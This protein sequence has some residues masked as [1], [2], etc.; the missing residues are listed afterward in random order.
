MSYQKKNSQRINSS[1]SSVSEAVALRKGFSFPAVAALQ[2]HSQGP[3]EELLQGK[4]E[5]VQKVEEE[6][7]L[8]GKF[9]P[10]QKAED[11]ELLQGKFEPVQK[12][13]DEELL[14]GKF[15]P[16]Q[17]VEEEEPLQGKFEP[18]QKAED[19]ELLQGKFEPVQK[20]EDEELLQGKFEPVQKVEEEEPL[21]GKFEPVQKVEDEELLQGKFEPVQKVEEEE[22]L[23]GKFETVQKVEEEE[24]LQGK[25]ETVQ[26]VEEEEPLQGKFESVQNQSVQLSN[27]D[28]IGKPINPVQRAE[29]APKENNTGLPDR[30]KSGIE[31]L[32]G[33]SLDD[34]KVHYNSAKPA[35]LQAHAYA[36]GTNIHVAP[37]QERHIAHE[38]WHVV[39]QKQGRVKPTLQMKSG[40][41][42]NDEE[43]LE[44]EADLMGAKAQVMDNQMLIN[45]PAQLKYRNTS[46]NTKEIP[47][48]KVIQKNEL[49]RGRASRSLDT[50]S[51]DDKYQ[52]MNA[53]VISMISNAGAV[54]SKIN[55]KSLESGSDN[56]ATAT[57]VG[58]LTASLTS[59]SGSATNAIKGEGKPDISGAAGDITLGIGSTIGVLVKSVV[60][61]KKG[62][63]S[64]K[65]KESTLVGGGETAIA[66]LSALKAGCEAAMSIQ[67]YVTGSVPPAIVSLIPGLGI[68][69][70]ACEVIKNAYT[71][72]NAYS[73]ESEMTSVS[74]EFRAELVKLLGGSPETSAPS[75]FANEKRGKYGNRITYLRLKPGL[76]ETLASIND[77]D[78]TS[79]QK[80]TRANNFKRIHNIPSSVDLN[81]LLPA[82]KY[83]ELG[84]KMQEINQK[85]KVQGA[86]NIFT[87]LLTMAG[88][89]AKFFPA[90][91]GITAGVLIGAAA[92]SGAV[93]SAGKFIQGLARDKGILSADTNRSSKNKHKE[94]VNH[95][96]T[97]YELFNS[98]PQPVLAEQKPKVDRCEQLL[99]STGVNL[100]TIYA[101]DY[102]D[103]ASI[104]NQVNHIISSMK[105]GR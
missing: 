32:S 7:P 63:D 87:N 54:L 39:Q 5:P 24:P 72:Y 84:S 31:N 74:G 42:V 37:G 82:I 60:A 68:A 92:A 71:G 35:Q 94:Y 43:N 102:S 4:F 26:K 1:N 18:V 59:A 89:I 21:Q 15:E 36:Q 75:L 73:A 8:Q 55:W 14:Q 62:Y 10:V 97:I 41:P 11:E 101:T 48:R 98:V 57:A 30:V 80:T 58:G 2:R 56:I 12:A 52:R 77:P 3:E 85:R 51:E 79:E 38:A 70:A 9:E 13:E 40:I 88:E 67:R 86:R 99:K 100:N 83:Y 23:Q 66:I 22:P 90:D 69:I 16:V 104:N 91:G 53:P 64:A 95:T 65:G 49:T 105:T 6:E 28:H 44:N 33:Y 17:K 93:Q 29:V 46:G 76:F 61:I 50:E 20:V 34:V 45:S 25:F 19:E 47:Q 78:I 96:K 27:N 81:L 103:D